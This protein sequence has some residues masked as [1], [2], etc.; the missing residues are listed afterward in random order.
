MNYET[1]DLVLC[2]LILAIVAFAALTLPAWFMAVLAAALFL[3][4]VALVVY[5]VRTKPR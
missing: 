2:C 1:L 4:F 5:S 3:G